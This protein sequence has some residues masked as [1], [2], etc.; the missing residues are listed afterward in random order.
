MK[1]NKVLMIVGN[2]FLPDNRVLRAANAL[3]DLNFQ[4]K[5]I[6]FHR[7]PL[8]SNEFINEIEI[9]R[10]KKK[11]INFIPK[12]FSNYIYRLRFKS[13]VKKMLLKDK[14]KICYCHDVDTLFMGQFGKLK[15]D[16]KVIYDNH[17]YFQDLNYLHRYPIL[18]RKKIA[19]YERKMLKNFVDNFIVVSEGIAKLY[20]PLYNKKIHIIRNIPDFSENTNDKI[21]PD[22]LQFLQEQQTKNKKVLIYLGT[23]TQKGRGFDFISKIF[24]HLSTQFSLLICGC[25]NSEEK[26]YLL[27]KFNNYNESVYVEFKQGFSQLKQIAPYLFAGLSLI[28]PIY[29]SYIHSLPNKLFEYIHLRIPIIASENPD[30]KALVEKYHLGICIPFEEDTAIKR[31]ISMKKEDYSLQIPVDLTWEKEKEKFKLLSCIEESSY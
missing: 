13:F 30:Q 2:Y 29:L 19:C 4:V 10:F 1:N 27:S 24:P 16:C 12:Q 14:P 9:I 17:E 23:N 5:I 20:K 22:L 6:A 28:E 31:I 7:N 26:S 21:N 8:L 18:I 3:K 25:T 11:N 15:L